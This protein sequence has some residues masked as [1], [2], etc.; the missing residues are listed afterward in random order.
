MNCVSGLRCLPELQQI[1]PADVAHVQVGED[2]VDV[3]V[4]VA[5]RLVGVLGAEDGKPSDFRIW[6][7]RPAFALVVLDDEDSPC[8]AHTTPR[9]STRIEP[10]LIVIPQPIAAAQR[11]N[12]TAVS[13]AANVGI[14]CDIAVERRLHCRRGAPDR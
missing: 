8:V 7:D 3:L 2:D 5:Q 13:S 6:H 11:S 14:C 9:L 1:D 12:C 10:R 4:D